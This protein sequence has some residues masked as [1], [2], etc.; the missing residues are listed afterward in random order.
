MGTDP[1]FDRLT[2]DYAHPKG[3]PHE[4]DPNGQMSNFRDGDGEILTFIRT[5]VKSL[6]RMRD[7]QQT[8]CLADLELEF[9]ITPAENLTEQERRDLLVPVRYPR[10]TTA[11]DTDM[12]AKLDSAFGVGT[13]FVYNNS[14]DGPAID[15]DLVLA[16]NFQMQAMGGANYYAGN[17][18]AYAGRSGGYLLMNGPVFNQSPAYL[19]AG[20]IF[21]GNT[22]AVAGYFEEL[23]RSLVEYVPSSNA[24]DWPF[25]WFVGGVATFDPVTGSITEIQ[26]GFLPREQKKRLDDMILQ[27]KPMFT[28]CVVVVTFT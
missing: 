27:F 15:P 6:A 28:G 1:T 14:P 2:I 10:A 23:K 22:I 5:D 16:T 11:N 25:N 13:L 3:P 19:G 9:G 12:Q 24:D 17:D 4:P 18:D 26:Q 8:P 7:P 21:A 20:Q